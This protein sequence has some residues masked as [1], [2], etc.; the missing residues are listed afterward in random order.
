MIL[1]IWHHSN[2]PRIITMEYTFGGNK[3]LMTTIRRKLGTDIKISVNR[4]KNAS[5]FP[6][7]YPLTVPITVPITTD[8]I[9]E[10]KPTVRDIL[11]P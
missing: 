10:R 9:M 5:T 4:I 6:P 8:I 11:P 2:N 1:A 7:I 3:A